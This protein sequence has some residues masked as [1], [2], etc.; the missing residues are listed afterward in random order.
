M[1]KSIFSQKKYILDEDK[2]FYIPELENYTYTSE[3]LLIR[4]DIVR[5]SKGYT[6]D[7]CTIVKD[8]NE[9]YV[10]SLLH[11]I[12]YKHKFKRELADKIFL[13]QMEIDKFKYAKIYY[14]GVRLFGWIFY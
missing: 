5:I 4:N 6:W 11:D 12:L 2:I 1:K 8:Y 7:G 3:E 9:T 10:A 14:Y 13:I